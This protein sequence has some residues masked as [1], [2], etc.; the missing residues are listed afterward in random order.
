MACA[1]DEAAVVGLFRMN[2]N[3]T[4]APINTI[5][6]IAPITIPAIAPPEID[7][8]DDDDEEE[9]EVAFAPAAVVAADAAIGGTGAVEAEGGAVVTDEDA[10]GAIIGGR[11]GEDV[12]TG[13]VIAG[14]G[15]GVTRAGL[16][17]TLLD[18]YVADARTVIPAPV[19]TALSLQ[20]PHSMRSDF[21]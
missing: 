8:D 16:V 13:L 12:A 2:R 4:K 14:S 9:E 20:H 3:Q 5:A 18:V 21:R 11:D 17:E 1:D 7:D 15:T 6:A 10:E 19:Q